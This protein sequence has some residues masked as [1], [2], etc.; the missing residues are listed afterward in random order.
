MKRQVRLPTELRWGE[1]RATKETLAIAD[2]RFD[3]VAGSHPACELKYNRYLMSSD[4]IDG[5]LGTMP[6]PSAR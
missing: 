6:A 4:R 3:W 5:V 1:A 2:G